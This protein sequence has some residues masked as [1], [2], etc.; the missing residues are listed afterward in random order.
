ALR[1]RAASHGGRLPGRPRRRQRLHRRRGPLAD[2]HA[3]GSGPEAHASHPGRRPRRAQRPGR[4]A[5]AHAGR[6]HAGLP[7]H[8]PRQPAGHARHL[9]A[10]AQAVGAA[11]ALARGAHRREPARA[12]HRRRRQAAPDARGHAQLQTHA[13]PDLAPLTRRPPSGRGGREGRRHPHRGAGLRHPAGPPAPPRRLRRRPRRPQGRAAARL[14]GL[15][16]GHGRHAG[17]RRGGAGRRR[18]A[19]HGGADGGGVGGVR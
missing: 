2:C 4:P 6:R 15:R 3:A 7:A 13:L 18:H 9:G 11:A 10:D 16:H 12:L 1:L 14:F 17:R 5:G 19:L 8:D